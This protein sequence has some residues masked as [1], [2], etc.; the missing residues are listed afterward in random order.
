MGRRDQEHVLHRPDRLP[1]PLR[2]FFFLPTKTETFSNRLTQPLKTNRLSFQVNSRICA[3]AAVAAVAGIMRRPQH[4]TTALPRE[5]RNELGL[6]DH[7]GEKKKR[8]RDAPVSRKD[9]RQAERANKSRPGAMSGKKSRTQPDYD[10]EVDEGVFDSDGSEEEEVQPKGKPTKPAENKPK[11]IL[12]KPAPAPEE[13]DSEEEDEEEEET[14]PRK[15]SKSVQSK[16]DEDDA[17]IAAL[18]KKLGMKKGRKLP[19]AF[20]DDG[21]GDLL[22]DLGDGSDDENRKRKREAD[23]WLKNKRRKAQNLQSHEESEEDGSEDEDMDMD[24]LDEDDMQD[25]SEE[26]MLGSDD[27]SDEEG[28]E[29]GG[30]DEEEEKPAPKKK[31]NPYV[32]PVPAQTENRPAKY[33]PP[34]L[35]AASGSESESLTRLRRQAQGHLNKLSEANLVSILSEFEKLYREYPRQHVTSTLITLLMGLICERSALQDTFLILHAGF[36]A[37]LYKVVGMDFGAELVQKVV[38]TFDAGGD[39][40]GSFEGKEHINLISLLSQLYN[41][42]VVGSP[43][44]FDYIRLFLQEITETNTE[45]LLKIIRSMLSL[46]LLAIPS[47]DCIRLRP[48]TP[49]R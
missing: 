18:E 4:N 48:S 47:T 34:S 9:R 23:D 38:E 7:Y 27:G 17:E 22:G 28:S 24:G 2:S 26:D 5:L 16:L 36:I 13:S 29:F 21:L 30:F 19:K 45:L 43:L 41:F 44:V 8:Q 49:P 10:E 31:E 14:R 3:A 32:A 1:P 15:V 12:K 33:I 6:K 37:A 46:P 20:T 35:R 42:H 40:R 39:E 11:T 25:G